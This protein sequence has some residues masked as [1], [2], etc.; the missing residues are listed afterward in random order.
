MPT[1]TL[2]VQM[3]ITLNM[4]VCLCEGVRQSE[5]EA[6]IEDGASNLEAVGRACGAGTGCGSCHESIGDLLVQLGD[7]KSCGRATMACNLGHLAAS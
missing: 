3:R 4:I 6:A 7:D 1:L 2:A 5:V